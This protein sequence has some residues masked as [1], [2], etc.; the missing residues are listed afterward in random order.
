MA[1][2]IAPVLLDWAGKADGSGAHA[3]FGIAASS[4]DIAALSIQRRS[5]AK[6]VEVPARLVNRDGA[7]YYIDLSGIPEMDAGTWDFYAI[8]KRTGETVRLS[9][10][11]AAIANSCKVR[12]GLSIGRLY[13]TGH[14]NLSMRVRNIYEAYVDE[15]SIVDQTLTMTLGIDPDMLQYSRDWSLTLQGLNTRE[16]VNGPLFETICEG[17]V[18]EDLGDEQGTPSARVL[19]RGSLDS[20]FRDLGCDGH[21]EVGVALTV[22][23]LSGAP[24]EQF[25][26]ESRMT[27][28][29]FRALPLNLSPLGD[30]EPT[31]QGAYDV[32]FYRASASRL[33]LRVLR[34]DLSISVDT[35]SVG[36]NAVDVVASANR[37][38]GRNDELSAVL[39]NRATGS[40]ESLVVHTHAPK[41]ITFSIPMDVESFPD[42]MQDARYDVAVRVAADKWRHS[43][44]LRP[45]YAKDEPVRF[46]S[47]ILD[48]VPTQRA[49][50]YFTGHGSLAISV[51][52][53]LLLNGAC[54][55]PLPLGTGSILSF[56]HRSTSVPSPRG[57]PQFESLH[58][59]ERGAR[60]EIPVSRCVRSESAAGATKLSLR[61]EQTAC[62]PQ[63][64]KELLGRAAL[65][66]EIHQEGKSSIGV[67][68]TRGT[69]PSAGG[70]RVQE[71]LEHARKKSLSWAKHLFYRVAR[72]VLPVDR[73]RV[74][75][76]SFLG[77]AYADS[78]RAISERLSE[79]AKRMRLVW[80]E[81]RGGCTKVPASLI[82]VE[83][84]SFRYY[85]QISRAKYFVS[86]TNFP[87]EL[88]KRP[89]QV[90]VQTWHGTPLKKI[91]L[92]VSARAPGYRIQDNPALHRRIARWDY[93]LSPSPFTTR[94]FASAFQHNARVL[95]EGYPRNDRLANDTART[96]A[97]RK[98]RRSL[99]LKDDD[100]LVLYM[101]TWR[102]NV[103]SGLR[104]ELAISIREFCRGLEDNVHLALRLHYTVGDEINVDPRNRRIHDVSWY[105]DSH[106]LLAAADLLITD[107]SSVL[108]D[109]CITSRPAIVF[110]YDL[111]MYEFDTRGFYWDLRRCSPYGLVQNSF[112]LIA[113]T[114]R[115]LAKP[116]TEPGEK[117]R[118]IEFQKT[119]APYEDGAAS[120]RVCRAVFREALHA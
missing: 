61:V 29:R 89:K 99:N 16:R 25:S 118:R 26:S 102:D 54:I 101:P 58:Y 65:F 24:Q 69:L 107:Y 88:V 116:K 57:R 90:H 51:S 4:G 5:T 31:R 70:S 66:V 117:K 94:V 105:E 6:R 106:D 73:R 20:L 23:Q 13:I 79:S 38:L 34:V 33:G 112:E 81:A 53:Q 41:T 59:Y 115:L 36:P 100:R 37:I 109:F 114:Q 55:R 63:F 108:Y 46:P 2:A 60:K 111:D 48:S 82:A 80:V 97:R 8:R 32:G 98:V 22:K 50:P 85:Y 72:R 30:I 67:L 7:L 17:P 45:Q 91:G 10:G 77:T 44:R 83:A 14:G 43:L 78:P 28:L 104:S 68:R 12:S 93:L 35:V 64:L 92:D 39:T 9:A 87:D 120:D 11:E 110:A 3:A 71:L 49:R 75:F 62:T 52:S 76:Q 19:L 113:E 47:A 27:R 74:V 119:F 15:V 1:D 40:Q 21:Y 84:R 56:G 18:T 86:N 95:E 103:P 42:G 96:L